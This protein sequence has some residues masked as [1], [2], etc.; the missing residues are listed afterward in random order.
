MTSD[1]ERAPEVCTCIEQLSREAENLA[2]DDR[3]AM[4]R[5]RGR[6]EV[7]GIETGDAR[8]HPPPLTAEAVSRCADRLT[9]LTPAESDAVAQ[10]SAPMTMPRTTKDPLDPVDIELG[11]TP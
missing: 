5:E 1:L 8:E 4:P 11:R 7:L 6:C 3:V 2:V 10:Q 9:T